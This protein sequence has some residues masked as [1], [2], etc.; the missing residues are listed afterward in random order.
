MAADWEAM[1]KLMIRAKQDPKLAAG[2][3]RL[4]SLMESEEGAALARVM[5]DGGSDVLKAASEA[6]LR[7][8]KAAAKAALARLL[9]TKEGAAAASKLADL[10]S[11]G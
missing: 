2:L 1:M 4:G 5:A 10:V 3:E 8:D 9:S 7:G 11:R 6:M